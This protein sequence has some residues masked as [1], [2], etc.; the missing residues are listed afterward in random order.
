[1]WVEEEIFRVGGM[2]NNDTKGQKGWAESPRI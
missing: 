2:I 1:M